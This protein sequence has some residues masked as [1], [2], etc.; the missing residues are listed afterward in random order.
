MSQCG[1]HGIKF[2]LDENTSMKVDIQYLLAGQIAMIRLL[3]NHIDPSIL[4]EFANLQVGMYD[5]IKVDMFDSGG[6]LFD[7]VGIRQESR[8]DEI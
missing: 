8:T 1:E 2:I 5:R 4:K 7:M 3:C 6:V